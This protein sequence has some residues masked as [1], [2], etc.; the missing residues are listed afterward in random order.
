MRARGGETGGE[1]RRGGGR[2]EHGVSELQTHGTAT[3]VAFSSPLSRVG[4]VLVLFA[5]TSHHTMHSTV[6]V[7]LLAVLSV[8]SALNVTTR[9]YGTQGTSPQPNKQ[10]QTKRTLVVLPSNSSSSLFR[11]RGRLHCSIDL[12][13]GHMPQLHHSWVQRHLLPPDKHQ[14][15]HRCL[16]QVRLLLLPFTSLYH[17]I[18]PFTSLYF[19]LPASPQPASSQ[20]HERPPVAIVHSHPS[21]LPASSFLLCTPPFFSASFFFCCAPTNLP[22][23]SPL[24][25]SP[26]AIHKLPRQLHR[27]SRESPPCWV[28]QHVHQLHWVQSLDGLL[29]PRLL[30]PPLPLCH[31]RWCGCLLV[32]KAASKPLTSSLHLVGNG[33]REGEMVKGREGVAQDARLHSL[34]FTKF[35]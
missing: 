32:V 11:M 31:R 26:Q 25:L 20:N 19:T 23:S 24:F 18:L 35:P 30:P 2:G 10:N 9:H 21:F 14:Q 16:G 1:E 13:C 15:R 4:F 7:L 29:Q 33:E 27:V 12:S 22:L 28:P 8:A 3:S 5:F 34:A 6:V 17:P